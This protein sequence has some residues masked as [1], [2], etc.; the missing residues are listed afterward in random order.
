MIQ[1]QIPDEA[2]DQLRRL[3][4]QEG[5]IQWEVGDFLV[6]YWDEM[7][8]HLKPKEIGDA[9]AKFIR[10]FAKGTGSDKSTLRDRKNMSMF[11]S[12]ADREK[13]EV[14]T[15]HQFRAL[16]SAGKDWEEYA[17]KALDEGWSVAETRHN[18]KKDKEQRP[19]YLVRLEKMEVQAN[20]I[21]AHEDTPVEV[22]EG[23]KLILCVIADT[24][25]ITYVET[26][27]AQE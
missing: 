9:H 25:E 27:K 8:S 14:F 20:K 3:L 26:T 6:A 12:H 23:V 24:K 10:D 21:V 15:Y 17:V 16:R 4:E 22:K 1:F 19:D 11:F 7:L 18:I 13:Y 5:G 2:L